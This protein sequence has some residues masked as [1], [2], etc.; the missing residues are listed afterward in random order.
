MWVGGVT[1]PTC[2]SCPGVSGVTANRQEVW[3]PLRFQKCGHFPTPCPKASHIRTCSRVSGSRRARRPPPTREAAAKRMGITLVTPTKE[4]KMVFPKMAPNLQSPL[5][6]PKAVALEGK[7]VS[8]WQ[9]ENLGLERQRDGMTQINCFPN[10]R[11]ST[12]A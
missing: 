1:R 8:E 7:G 6:R 2:L 3:E 12:E 11:S 5:R 4:A 9:V 10:L